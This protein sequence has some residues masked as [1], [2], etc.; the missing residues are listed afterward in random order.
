[1][2]MQQIIS[3]KKEQT[4]EILSLIGVQIVKGSD[5]REIPLD[6]GGKQAECECC[7]KKLNLEN[8]GN[9]AKGSVLLFC[10]NPFCF[11]SHIVKKVEWLRQTQ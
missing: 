4:K 10:D 5:N 9:I 11:T 2:S 1:M 3:F 6:K 7:H 8:I